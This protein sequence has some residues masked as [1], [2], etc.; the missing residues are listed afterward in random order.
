MIVQKVYQNIEN[1][2]E[3]IYQLSSGIKVIKRDENLVKKFNIKKW[4]ELSF[5]PEDFKEINRNISEEEKKDLSLFLNSQK[6]GDKGFKQVW[7]KTKNKVKSVF[8]R[9]DKS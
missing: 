1:D 4:E 3:I 5:I 7:Q 6:E 9:K 2:T 8:I